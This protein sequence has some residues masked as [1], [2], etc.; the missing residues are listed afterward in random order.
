MALARSSRKLVW[1]LG[2]MA[3]EHVFYG[4][5]STG[6]G[7]DVESATRARGLDGRRRA[8]WGPSR[9]SSTA[10]SPTD[11]EVEEREK[12]VMERFERIGTADHEPRA[13]AA[14]MTADPI[15]GV[16]GDRGKRTAAAQI[17][18]QAY[19]AA[20]ALISHN[21]DEVEA[22][23]EALIERREMHGDEVVELLDRHDLAS[24]TSTSSDDADLAEAVSAR[25]HD[26]T[27]PARR[28]TSCCRSRV[29]RAETAARAP[30]REGRARASPASRR[31]P[32]PYA[33]RFRCSRRSGR[34]SPSA[35]W[36]PPGCSSP[37]GEPETGAA[38]RRGSRP[39]TT[40]GRRRADRRARRPALQAAHGRPARAVAGGE[41][42][43]GADADRPAHR[44]ATR[45][46]RD[47]DSIKR[48]RARTVLYRLCGL[49][50]Q[51]AINKGKP[52]N[53]RGLL[54]QREALELALYSFRY[55]D[56]VKNV[57]ALMPPS[58]GKKP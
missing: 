45:R 46:H 16:L 24:P 34:R 47:G 41:L 12:Q 31:R 7:G 17:L 9:S 3:A 23:A 30:R 14:A 5:N 44:A 55:L 25:P 6:V 26:A 32:P 15:G 54:L 42:K 38:G 21:R 50:A 2:A 10:A 51:C 19:L 11:D 36:P 58:P 1:T 20:H 28:S 53:E 22:I 57:V 49:G 29:E 43:V 52:S 35:R 39:T 48:S 37:A 40:S 13:A 27:A 18:G 8:A 33:P 56:G 4:E